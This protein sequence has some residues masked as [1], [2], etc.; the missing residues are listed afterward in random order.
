MG[1]PNVFGS[2]TTSIPLSQLDANFNTGLTI[3]NTTIGLGNTTTTLGNVILTNATIS[4]PSGI[5][6]NAVIYSTSTGN[7]TGNATIFSVNSGNV[8][9]GT[10][11]PTYRLQVGDGTADTR[12]MFVSNNNFSIGVGRTTGTI[13]GYIGSPSSN[14]MV[15]SGNDGTEKMRID[16][17]GNVGIGVIDQTKKLETTNTIATRGNSTNA[18]WS[19]AGEI[20]LKNASVTPY[21]S[22]HNDVGGRLA[23]LQAQTTGT[24]LNAETGY[25]AFST[26]SERMRIL[27]D[28]TVGIGTTS[29]GAKLSIF[30]GSLP[31]PPTGGVG[32]SGGLTTGRFGTYDSG[33]LGV[34]GCAADASSFEFIAGSSAGYYAGI[35]I[36][37]SNATLYQGTVRF[38]T[39]GTE[40][41]RID[42]SGNLLVGGTGLASAGN[43]YAT[44]RGGDNNSIETFRIGTGTRTQIAFYNGTIGSATNVGTIQTSGS[45]TSYN[46]SSDYRLKENIAPMTGA[47]DKVAQLKPCTYVWKRDSVPSQG[48]IAHELAEV[49]P[50]CVSGEKDAVDAEGNPVYQGIDTSFLVATLTAAIQE[51]NAKVTALEAQLGAK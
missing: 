33:T 17:S 43:S 49:M 42:S 25:L 3:G 23:Y 16:S 45:N 35:S 6:A 21:I 41:M 51:L 4:S 46:T 34:I 31:N 20:A 14:V 1:V 27:A 9:I 40:R 8:G 19:N 29:P 37:G 13:G 12:G 22:W 48:F 28:G 50:D 2:A 30:G 10:S 5:A 24:E 47:L 7:L 39:A 15:F 32:I 36:T 26:N 44:L 11:S 38:A 18:T